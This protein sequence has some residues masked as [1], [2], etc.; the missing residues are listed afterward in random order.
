MSPNLIIPVENQVRELEPKVLLAC[1]AAR[2]GFAAVIGSRLEVDFHIASFPRSIYLSKSMT[3]RSV[4]MFRIMRKLGHQIAVWDEEALVH[5]P[6]ETYFTRRLSPRAIDEV[7]HLFAWGEENAELWRNYPHYAQTP[8]HITGN[9]R[10]DML[11]PELRV[12]YTDLAQRL[13]DT[14]GDFILINTNF[15]VV[16]AFNPS[17]NLFIPGSSL[18]RVG[19]AAV[20]MRR[21]YATGLRD[22]KQALFEHFQQLVPALEQAFPKINIVIRPHPVE[23]PDVY[24]DIAASSNRV[25]VATDG[26]VIP[27]LMAARMVIHNGCTTGVEAY[28]LEVP[29]IAYQPSFNEYYDEAVFRLPNRLSHQVFNFEELTENVRQILDGS[30]EAAGGEERSDLIRPFLCAQTGP[31]AS[32]RIVDVLAAATDDRGEQSSPDLGR[33]IDGWQRATRRR[34]VKKLKGWSP[35][36]K[37]RPTFQRHRYPGLTLVEMQELVTRFQELLG[38]REPLSVE[39]VRDHVFRIAA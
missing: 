20:G 38:D 28:A 19:R 8:I 34:V 7:A 23:K 18:E 16:N 3:E 37:Y 5:P 22:H 35:G 26:N 6:A 33:W 30:R 10:G 25:Q 12:F 24:H 15:G 14:Y 27:W 4:K 32:E 11:R 39:R 2:R 17:Q 21:D 9:P 1:L 31:L 36:S 13:R 29:A